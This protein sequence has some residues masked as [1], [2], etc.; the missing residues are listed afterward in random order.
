MATFLLAHGDATA[1]CTSTC[2]SELRACREQCRQADDR[3]ACRRR[4]A[5]ASTC[6]AP[7]TLQATGAYPV[8]ECRNDAAGFSLRERLVVRRGN[9]DPV[10][11]MELPS[12][13]PVADPYVGVLG[14]FGACDLYGKYRVGFG[15]VVVGRFQRIG[16][17]PDAKHVIIEVTNDHVL[18]GLEALSPEPPE[19]GIFSVSTD[20]TRRERLGPPSARPII[21]SGLRVTGSPFFGIS[22]D[23]RF[24]AFEDVGPGPD[25]LDADQIAVIDLATRSRTLVTQRPQ[26]PARSQ[27]TGNP[28]FVNNR[29]IL[30]FDG[31]TGKRFT[32]D[33][34]GSHL[35]PVPDTSV[36]D[37]NVV[38]DFGLVGSGGNIIKGRFPDRTPIVDLGVSGAPVIELFFIKGPRALQLT[39]FD[40]PDTGGGFRSQLARGRAFFVASADPL[41]RN[42]ENICQIFSVDTLGA[43]LRQLTHFPADGR[44]KHGCNAGADFA[45]SVSGLGV[46]SMT[47]GM[48]FASS[49]DPRGRNPNG[50]QFFSMRA[51]GSGLRQISAFRGVERVDGGV[52]VEMAGPP[53]SSL[54]IH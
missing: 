52:T 37:G 22:P 20:G 38:L 43:G 18:P 27:R 16:V 10:T 7:G 25:G 46:D 32:V 1:T 26:A 29:T 44:P 50:E 36:T 39:L 45:C 49:C 35:E 23:S 30:F 19:E 41:G 40:Y 34:D 5:V 2:T 28:A 15:S 6:E 33:V 53:A 17:T 31:A 51:D 3:R 48:L 47:G 24:V 12:V 42:S 11:V 14:S 8:N 9:C 4:C 21:E 54:V 13:G